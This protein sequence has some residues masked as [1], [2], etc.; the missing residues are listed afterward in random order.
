LPAFFFVFS[1]FLY[2]KYSSGNSD[3]KKNLYE[4]EIGRLLCTLNRFLKEVVMKAKNILWILFLFIGFYSVTF[5]ATLQEGISAYEQGQVSEARTIFADLYE[6]SKPDNANYAKIMLYYAL[7]RLK[8]SEA[9][10]VFEKIIGSYPRQEEAAA[11]AYQI[12]NYYSMLGSYQKANQYFNNIINNL[13]MFREVY[14]KALLKSGET[15]IILQEYDMAE[16]RFDGY[17]NQFPQ[18]EHQAQ[19]YLGL[20]IC[21][22]ERH[23]YRSALPNFQNALVKPGKEDYMALALYRLGETY[24]ALANYDEA[25][26]QYRKV[27]EYY[28]GS[29]EALKADLKIIQLEAA[30]TEKP[31]EEA[32]S[33]QPLSP[34]QP[35]PVP[36]F[37]AQ[38]STFWAAQVGAWSVFDNAKNQQNAL[39]QQGYNTVQ[40]VAF[41]REDQM[42]Y[43]VVVGQFTSSVEAS[44][45]S[46]ELNHKGIGSFI[47]EVPTSALTLPEI[48]E[49]PPTTN[50]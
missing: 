7:T 24:E 26:K 31:A 27:S 30:Q 28:P 18:G 22:F 4:M 17:L 10:P 29:N 16:R 38:D 21:F 36:N 32:A 33:T 23:D 14:A 6:R 25:L 34:P 42:L 19:A 1:K 5:A 3:L 49:T 9:I 13:S 45:L 37:G 35:P 41:Q 2:P 50:E 47:V 12:G 40:I 8:A 11:A 43:K 20:G 48:T 44:Q 46:G 15:E 39:L